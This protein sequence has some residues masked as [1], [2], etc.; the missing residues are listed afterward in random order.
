MTLGVPFLDDV[1]VFS[2]SGTTYCLYTM[3]G[4]VCSTA[5]FFF[6]I[7]L[8]MVYTQLSKVMVD[9]ITPTLL[10][11]CLTTKTLIPPYNRPSLNWEATVRLATAPL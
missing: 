9:T 10:E 5:L 3:S 1:G 8:N 6:Y 2:H 11:S 4:H 7:F